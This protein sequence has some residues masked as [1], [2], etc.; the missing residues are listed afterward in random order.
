MFTNIPT[1]LRITSVSRLSS[2]AKFIFY[3]LCKDRHSHWFE[4]IAAVNSLAPP[5][6][7]LSVDC[8]NDVILFVRMCVSQPANLCVP[9]H[10][11]VTVFIQHL[12][13]FAI[14]L[15]FRFLLFDR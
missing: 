4:F 11:H 13:L 12:V 14:I 8:H 5:L 2:L 6:T 9:A 10:G 3:Q 7:L 1:G 15:C